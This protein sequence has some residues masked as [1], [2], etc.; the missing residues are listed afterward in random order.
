MAVGPTYGDP[1]F[2]SSAVSITVP[3]GN[4]NLATMFNAGC[5]RWLYCATAGII[6]VQHSLDAGLVAYTVIAGTRLPGG[7]ITLGGTAAG[8]TV[9]V[10]IAEV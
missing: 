8:T 5:A 10:I 7:F 6:Y 1:T 2:P 9:A 4:T 3:S